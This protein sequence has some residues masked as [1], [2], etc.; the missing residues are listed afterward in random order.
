MKT[1]SI[2]PILV[3]ASAT[4]TTPGRVA[5]YM[6]TDNYTKRYRGQLNEENAVLLSILEG[7]SSKTGD[8]F[9]RSLVKELAS[10]LNTYGALVA[11]YVSEASQLRPRA[12]WLGDRWVEPGPYDIA[13]TPCEGVI[14]E[15]K[16]FQIPD[17]VIDHYPQNTFLRDYDLVS[18]TGMPFKDPA[19]NIIGHLAVLDSKPVPNEARYMALFEIFGCRAAAEMCRIH[20]EEELR[21]REERLRRLI[22]GALDCIIDF[23]DQFNIR[24]ANPSARQLFNGQGVDDLPASV[25]D[26]FT[27]DSIQL[28]R[29]VIQSFHDSPGQRQ[30][31]IGSDLRGKR[32]DG[33]TFEIEATLSQGTELDPAF[34]TLIFRD[35]HV[36]RDAER[37]IR[38]LQKQADL[39]RDEL[40]TLEE[41]GHIIGQSK[42]FKAALAKVS[43]VATTAATVLL[44]G[45]TGSGKEVFA[46]AIHESSARSDKPLVTVN[47]AAI[48]RDLVESEFF[49]HVKGAFT[50]ATAQRVGRFMRADGGTIF[51]D[52]V[53]EL[54]LDVQAK[55]LRVLQEGEFEPV[56]SSHT[57]RVD[58]RV[59]AATNRRLADA[60]RAGQFREDL[61][62]RLNVFPIEIP[63]LKARGEDILLLAEFF[64]ERAADRFGRARKKLN[65]EHAQRLLSYHWPGNVREL[66]NIVEHAV[67]TSPDDH[68][69]PEVALD[70]AAFAEQPETPE[71]DGPIMTA[72]EMRAMQRTNIIR[73]LETCNG[74]IAGQ[75][76]AARMLNVKPSTL[77][78]QIKALCIEF[79]EL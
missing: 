55:L 65:K 79:K 48:P 40:D 1:A 44:L 72:D 73:A 68:L 74:R 20:A 5:F 64:A 22:E 67:I 42:L 23:D 28:L 26:W 47:C 7:T 19:G 38:Q 76:G 43:Q 41:R 24:L 53:A 8:D 29:N 10:V 2:R 37:R 62:Y 60:V 9:F 50:G 46:R 6:K 52:E 25:H 15:G 56:G 4:G 70:Q 59:I 27:D 11:D 14:R 61:F 57:V 66:Q 16:L 63:P 51:L 32:A 49:G 69:Y 30:A 71:A 58:V 78:S 77:R 12:Y 35:V 54:P 21:G 3:S 31:W 75:R 34:Y 33:G 45:E 13:G 39:L 17:R 36:L 18:Y